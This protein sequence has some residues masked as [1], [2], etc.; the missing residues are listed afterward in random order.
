MSLHVHVGVFSGDLK[1]QMYMYI[2]SEWFYKS[3]LQFHTGWVPHVVCPCYMMLWQP[4]HCNTSHLVWLPACIAPEPAHS[5][6]ELCGT[7]S[8][9]NFHHIQVHTHIHCHVQA[10]TIY[11]CILYLTT[12]YTC[13][14]HV[15]CYS[16]L[17]MTIVYPISVCV[18]VYTCT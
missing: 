18:Q 1:L 17:I 2:P 12:K 11:T 9:T 7:Q 4:S 14:H 16:K 3:S 8:L 13:K 15:C 10:K 5:R 6:T